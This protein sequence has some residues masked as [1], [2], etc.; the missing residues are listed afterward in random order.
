MLAIHHIR[1]KVTVNPL[2]DPPTDAIISV[3]NRDYYENEN[4]PATGYAT[5]VDIPYGDEL[6][7]TWSS[8]ISGP[9]GTGKEV[10]LMLPAGLHTVTLKVV[11]SIG[12]R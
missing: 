12:A 8:N 2:N 7:F 10:N 4:L 3:E 5:D 11:D 9:I 1:L 6:T